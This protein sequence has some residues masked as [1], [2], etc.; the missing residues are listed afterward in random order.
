MSIDHTISAFT[1]GTE[2]ILNPELITQDAAQDSLGWLTKEGKLVLAY[3]R[4]IIGNDLATNG[5]VQGLWFGYRI[6][7][8]TIMY[9]KI[10]TKIQYL[11]GSTWTDIIT[12]LTAGADYSFANYSSLAGVFTYV[13]GID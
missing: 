2:N 6:N 5:T 1:K 7:G 11:K 3:G 13:G 8:T 10:S 9:R 4:N 12:G